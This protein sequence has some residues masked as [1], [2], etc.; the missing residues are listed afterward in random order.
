VW[1]T[2]TTLRAVDS[3]LDVMLETRRLIALPDNDFSYASFVDQE[4]ALD[5]IDGLIERLRAGSTKTGGMAVLF[6]P[7]GPLQEVSLSSGWG[8]EFVA[9]ADRFDVANATLQ[10]HAV[11]L[12]AIC[13]QEAG[14]VK[15]E[16]DQLVRTSFTSTLTQAVTADVRAAIASAAALHALD[17]EL[18][19]FYCPDCERTYCGA[20]WRREDVFEDGFHEGIRGTCPEG[21]ERLLED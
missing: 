17:P 18:A 9:L 14:R 12:C 4:A 8:D 1:V 3:L 16:G 10:G 11:H 6:L 20:H 13:R 5:E 19:P 2:S 15:I 7:T 21:H